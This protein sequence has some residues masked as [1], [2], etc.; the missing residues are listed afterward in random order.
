M[1]HIVLDLVHTAATWDLEQE[2]PPPG[3]GD[4]EV[5][6]AGTSTFSSQKCAFSSS[7]EGFFIP[8]VLESGTLEGA[9]IPCFIPR[10]SQREVLFRAAM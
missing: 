2:F 4:L 1:V 3:P 9:W 5:G 8:D 10:N 7:M 6:F